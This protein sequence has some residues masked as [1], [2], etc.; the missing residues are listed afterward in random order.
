M[1]APFE[2]TSVPG[3][4]RR[5]GRYVVTFTDDAGTRR[6]RSAATMA[7][8]R[9][10]R[11]ELTAAVA[12]GEYR[13][14][15][16]VRTAS[17]DQGFRARRR[18]IRYDRTPDSGI[19]RTMS[20]PPPRQFKEATVVRAPQEHLRDGKRDEFTTGDLRWTPEPAPGRQEIIDLNVKC[21]DEGVEVGVHE[22]S[23]VDVAISNASFGTLTAN[24][25]QNTS[26]S[27]I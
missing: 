23:M 17:D 10:L 14:V 16:R 8:A 5:G 21:D 12:R 19:R 26:E 22:A 6:K 1:G 25:R 24:P 4:Y 2:R 3:I 20:K 13:A 18:C 9:V 7:E 15:A 11:S 27:T